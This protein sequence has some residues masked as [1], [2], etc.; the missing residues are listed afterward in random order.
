[1]LYMSLI[2]NSSSSQNQTTVTV[3]LRGLLPVLRRSTG[4]VSSSTVRDCSSAEFRVCNC[5]RHQL[6]YPIDITWER[7]SEHPYH[8]SAGNLL[9]G[10]T[11]VRRS[12]FGDSFSLLQL[13]VLNF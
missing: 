2:Q 3:F 9:V 8:M 13:T 10:S 5:C 4:R 7:D 6:L 12:A 1:M 11:C